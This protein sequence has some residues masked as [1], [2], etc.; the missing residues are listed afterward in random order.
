MAIDQFNLKD[1]VA[2][3]VNNE[4][5]MP[6]F[7]RGFVWTPE[8]TKSFVES[9]YYEY[10]I[11]TILLWSPPSEAEEPVVGMI[12]DAGTP[13]A[14]IVDGQQ[15]TTSLCLL[16]GRRP[17]WWRDNGHDWN[18]ALEK[19]DIHVNPLGEEA[20]FSIPNRRTKTNKDYISL[21]RLL[22]ADDDAITEIAREIID[23]HSKLDFFR[24]QV[25]LDRVRKIGNQQIVA[26]RETKDLEDI[27]EI[28]VRLNQSG[29][30][31]TEGDI[32][33]A[34]VA[35]HNPRWIS[36]EFQ[37]FMQELESSGFDLDSNVIYR[38][39]IATVQGRTRFKDAE[40]GFWESSNLNA[41]WPTVKNAWLN[42]INGL[43]E[44][45]I[46]SS[47]ILPSKN[48]LIPLVVMAA[49]FGADF[50]IKPALAWLLRATCTNRYSR[51][52]DTRLV[53]DIRPLRIDG[54][55]F[56]TAVQGASNGLARLDFSEDGTE[57]FRRSYN[58]G[59]V[60]L[61]LYLLAYNNK[62][63]DWGAAQERIGFNGNVALKKFNPDFHHIFPRANLKGKIETATDADSAANI[64]C[65]RKETNLKIGKQDPSEYMQDISDG[66]L[67]EQFVPTDRSLFTLERYNEF[68][69][70]R[71]E[72]L[73]KAANEFM[74]KLSEE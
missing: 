12:A 24:L 70:R 8:K 23:R 37:P 40:R 71:A 33:N 13:N 57:F 51:T 74:D 14:W 42:V 11:G 29:T 36:Q 17:Y 44:Y 18:L 50:R 3:S 21:R 1:I 49:R 20:D 34:L 38:S 56:T 22:T 4:Y 69:D 62:A 67:N 10:P 41:H 28:F 19:F 39:L 27:V 26:F 5:G 68:L 66:L 53:E 52:T 6:E 60:S 31:V 32:T 61:M 35:Q 65:I 72:M 43:N 9:L 64:A 25:K 48:A 46:L 63:R 15:R 45:G 73:A 16:F 54:S 7:Q 55:D 47:D 58:D 2:R 30:K 59:S